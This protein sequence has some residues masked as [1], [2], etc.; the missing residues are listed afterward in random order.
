MNVNQA[1][2]G[3]QKADVLVIGFWLCPQVF[4]GLHSGPGAAASASGNMLE[5]QAVMLTTPDILD[6]KLW[7]QRPAVY[8]VT[9]PAGDTAL[10]LEKYCLLALPGKETE[11]THYHSQLGFTHPHS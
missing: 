4:P 5:M 9:S 6:Q 10:R 7:E 1:H 3:Y 8:G 11:A 2:A